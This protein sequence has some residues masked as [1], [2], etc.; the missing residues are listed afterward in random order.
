VSF[1]FVVAVLLS[2]FIVGALARF[3]LPGPDPMPAW[4][5]V[6]IGLV[7]SI[8]GAVVGDV[9]T[10]GSGVA[11]SLVAFAV[12][13][14]LVAAYRMVVQKRPIFGP[15]ALK[16]PQ[17]GVGIDRARERLRKVG[18]DPDTLHPDPRAVQK[19]RLR[20]AIDEL[21]RSGLLDD[22][23]RETML[24]RLTEQEAEA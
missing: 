13:I 18:V 4:L 5:T 6:A 3:A 9:A 14:G 24:A 20:A 21:H 10:G 12:A 1:S 17:R 22:E 15:E 8:V 2:A 23:E 11:E 16:F 7:G 19:I